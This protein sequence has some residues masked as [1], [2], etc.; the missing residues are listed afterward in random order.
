MKKIVALVAIAAIAGGMIFAQPVFEPEVTLDGNATVK[1][2]VDLDAGQTG[3][4]NEEGGDFK[5]KLWGDGSR[6]L[7]EGDGIWAE[8]KVTGKELKFDGKK[9]GAERWDGG[10]W[11]LNEA[12]IHINDFYVGIKKGDT[13]VGEYK[14]D[15]AL[16]SAD[17]DNAKWLTNVGPKDFSQGITLGYGND[18]FAVDVDLRSY[19]KDSLN[20]HYTSAY[21][22]ALEAKLK[23]SNE[24]VEG[25][26]VD[27]G[28]GYNLSDNVK[29]AKA[30][31]GLLFD[32]YFTVGSAADD[33]DLKAKQKA[34]DDDPTWDNYVALEKYKADKAAADKKATADKTRTPGKANRADQNKAHQLGYAFNASYK[35][36][37]DDTYYV[38]PAI[39]LIGA[40]TTVKGK[41]YSMSNNGNAL[42]IGALF[43]WGENADANAGVP[44]LD[45]DNIK[46]VTPGISVVAYIP[47]ATSQKETV[48]SKTTDMK[49]HNKIIAF[50]VPSVYLGDDL[51]E[52]LKFAA[53]S[54]IGLLRGYT[55]NDEHNTYECAEADANAKKPEDVSR[56]FGLA[57]AMG[58]SYDIALDDVTVT[59]K[60]GLRYA[61]TAYNQNGLNGIAPYADGT[62]KIFATGYELITDKK[63]GIGQKAKDNG[64]DQNYFNLKLGVDVKGL[65]DNTTFFAEYTSANLMNDNE[66]TDKTVGKNEYD[67]VNKFYNQK[68]GT[69]NVG[70]KISF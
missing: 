28:L 18:N 65:I 55:K 66:Y 70:A 57:F 3:F 45:K 61:N 68:L 33:E 42:V 21:G 5:V 46:K 23:D 41:D 30:S 63:M 16:R 40:N 12:K 56:T 54:E 69:F 10:K 34:Y 62:D 35:F 6:E 19:Y 60:A 67:E 38:K 31:D 14:F 64:D 49:F 15:G 11:E 26:A 44:F 9:E 58:V 20:T 53:Y 47:F 13:Q 52:G 32:D 7:E 51:V 36:A 22:V 4:T 59:P 8:L 50:I 27:A 17:S 24:W 37:I 29:S 48:G 2:G 25:L 39:G 43:G 1:W